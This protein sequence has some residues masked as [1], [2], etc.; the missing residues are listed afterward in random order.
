MGTDINETSSPS[1]ASILT[2]I[3]IWV[4]LIFFLVASEYAFFYEEEF[5][6]GTYIENS[7]PGESQKTSRKFMANHQPRVTIE[8]EGGHRVRAIY[9]LKLGPKPQHN[10][11]VKEPR[12]G[13]TGRS[14]YYVIPAN[15]NAKYPRA[16]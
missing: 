3:A 1:T 16:K 2:G 8:L 10:V 12:S 14:R 15:S 6:N 13:I 4:F 11:R 7:L 9:D 5:H